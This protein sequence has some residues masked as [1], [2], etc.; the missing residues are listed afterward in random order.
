MLLDFTLLVVLFPDLGL[1]WNISNSD[2]SFHCSTGFNQC[3][4]K[5]PVEFYPEAFSA[6][7]CFSCR[8][9]LSFLD[10]C[11]LTL[12]PHTIIFRS[13]TVGPCGSAFIS[14]FRLCVCACVCVCMCAHMCV[15]LCLYDFLWFRG[16][17]VLKVP[18]NHGF[19]RVYCL[20][21]GFEICR[22]IV[23]LIYYYSEQLLE[24]ISTFMALTTYFRIGCSCFLWKLNI[25]E[26]FYHNRFLQTLR[27]SL[28]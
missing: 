12:T 8:L 26:S 18:W 21:K 27:V 6:F 2:Y 5:W 16:T 22:N 3:L 23:G 10:G 20:F 13:H 17:Q 4:G 24:Q 28:L 15:L 19:E 7:S 11:E 25:L 14:T 1:F 9:C